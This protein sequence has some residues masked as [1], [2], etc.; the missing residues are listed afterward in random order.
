MKTNK[1]AVIGGTGKSGNY[2]VQ[3]LLEKGYPMKLLL[4][5]PEN[6]TL[7]NP[8]IEIV[9]GD[10][11]DFDSVDR[12]IKDCCAVINKIGQPVGEKSIFTDAA[13][14]II[15]SMN[16]NG[17]TRYIAITGLNVDTPFDHKNDKV[18]MATD[19]MYQN[20]PKTTKDKQDEY[21]ILVNSNLDWTLV[22]LPLIIPTSEHFKTEANLTDCT[23]EKISAADLSEFLVSQISDETYHKQSPFL[24]NI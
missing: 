10:A 3:Q 14:N 6:F 17:I 13:K 5:N 12:L 9:K 23:G 21:E 18:K 24:Y 7:E 4:R 2:L 1:I 15:K 11:R 8:L 20:Y 19:W 16:L 22:R